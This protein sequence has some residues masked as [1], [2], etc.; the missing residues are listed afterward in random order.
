MTAE[1]FKQFISHLDP[2][3]RDFAIIHLLI[4]GRVQEVAGLTIPYVDLKN[5]SLIIEKVAIWSQRTKRFMHL[6]DMPKNEETRYCYITESMYEILARRLALIPSGCDFIFHNEGKP[7]TYRQ[8]QY[9][10]N[11]ALI[12]ANLYSEFK[13]THILRHAMATITRGVTGSRDAT[14][15]VTGHKSARMVEHYA[16]LPSDLQKKSVIAVDKVLD[17][18][19]L[20]ALD[21][22][23]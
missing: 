16:L 12:K 11:K 6:K 7:L 17:L 10:Y 1:Q 18:E 23:G 22:V 14:Q 9:H 15:A 5:R 4:S 2:F 8:I 3:W 13:S 20:K 19:P 21:E